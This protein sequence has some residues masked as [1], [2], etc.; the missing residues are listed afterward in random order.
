MGS[1]LLNVLSAVLGFALLM[2]VHELGHHL[3]A[4][5]F[6]MRVLRFSI[7]FGPAL[8]RHQPQGS[9]TVYQVAL[10]PFLAYVQ[11]DGMNPF[12]EVDP[13]DKGSYANASLIARL[14]TVVAGPLANY[15]FAVVLFFATLMIGGRQEPTTVVD[16][17]DQGAAAESPMRDG[18]QIVR[19]GDTSIKSFEQMRQLILRS[20]DKPLTFEVL[21]NN[22]KKS[23]QIT[24]RP[25]GPDHGGLIGVIPVP[26]HV[27]V[28]STE[29]FSEAAKKPGLIIYQTMEAIYMAVTR[30]GGNVQV[31]GPLGIA[32]AMGDAA[33]LGLLSYLHFLGF[34][35]ASLC[36]L[37]LFPWPA[38]DGGRLVF[39]LYEAAARRKSNSRWEAA[40]HGI[41]MLMLLVLM[42]VVT[43]FDFKD[44]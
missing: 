2:V 18:D 4:R 35:S 11:I 1:T 25:D 39:L 38:L 15:G 21:R 23:F 12:E 9:D 3:V 17:Q 32:S 14:L 24:P 8:W 19:I 43:V 7:G 42:I 27:E 29:A 6:K 20:P 10:L 28:A 33:D 37:N 5:A 41:G 30:Q 44:F 40:I 22:T 31:S 34:L 16:V 36:G 13:E 26:R